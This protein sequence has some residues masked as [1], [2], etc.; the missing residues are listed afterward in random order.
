MLISKLHATG[1]DFLVT[2]TA[3]DLGAEVAVGLCDR[4]TGVGADGLIMM[5]PASNGADATMVLR[6]ADG[7]IAE[8]SGNGIRCLAWAAVRDGRAHGDSLVVDTGGGRRTLELVVKND[9]LVYA[10]CDMGSAVF[11]PAAIPLDASSALDLEAQVDGTTYRGDAVGMGNPHFVLL[12]NDVDDVPLHHHGRVL[13]H[14]ARFPNRTNVEFV[15]HAG[16]DRVRMVVWER[17]VG[18]T[19][20]CGTGACAAASVAHRRGLTGNRV[21]VDVPGGTLD[22]SI[23]STLRLGGPVVQVFDAHLDPHDLVP[24]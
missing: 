10:T 13:E 15:Q 6:N 2:A 20:S 14:D 12:V 8:M 22:V 4:H 23:D 16:P 3:A 9:E 11:E 24:R 1:N 21:T 7:G 19:L 5:L 17:G 18:E